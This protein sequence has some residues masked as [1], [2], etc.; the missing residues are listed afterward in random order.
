MNGSHKGR[1]AEEIKEL[2]QKV[3]SNI[4]SLEK[5][6]KALIAGKGVQPNQMKD[7]QAAMLETL[8]NLRNSKTLIASYDG[9]DSPVY[10]RKLANISERVESIIQDIREKEEKGLVEARR[11]MNRLSENEETGEGQKEE[12]QKLLLKI[13]GE[14]KILEETEYMADIIEE[15]QLEIN[16]IDQI[17]GDVRDIAKDFALEVNDQGENLLNLDNNME[18]VASNTKEATKQLKEA[19]KRS[20]SNGKCLLIIALLIL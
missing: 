16:K 2:L 4:V 12:Q 17:M 10:K 11:S 3:N 9:N 1:S 8:N 7:N 13:G 15:R 19:N 18:D 14:V 6:N 20:K 5:Y